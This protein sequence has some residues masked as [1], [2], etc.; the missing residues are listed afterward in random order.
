MQA[1]VWNVRT[2]RWMERDMTNGQH[3]ASARGGVARSNVETSVMGAERR[4]GLSG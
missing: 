3:D 1:L 2:S 4:G